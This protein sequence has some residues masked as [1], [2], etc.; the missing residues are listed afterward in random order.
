MRKALLLCILILGALQG[1]SQAPGWL[2]AKQ[3]GGNGFDAG[4]GIGIDG[5]GNSY[6]VGQ[7]GSSPITFGSTVLTNAGAI[8]FSGEIRPFRERGLGKT[9]RRLRE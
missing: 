1:K 5:S 2:R 9:R 8:I 4:N 6:V 7:F 3:S